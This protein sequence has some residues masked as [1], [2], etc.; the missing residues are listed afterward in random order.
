MA[1]AEA[2]RRISLDA[3][4]SI[5]VYTP[6]PGSRGTTSPYWGLQYRFV[7]VTGPHTAGLA[8]NAANEL[9]VGVLVNKPQTV[10]DAASVAISGVSY[11]QSGA[12]ITAGQ[13]LK[14]DSNGRAVPATVGTDKVLAIALDA[15]TAANQLIPGLLRV[16]N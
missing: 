16:S 8:T 2:Q 3:D 13:A 12:A 10:G 1:Y 5:G 4:A 15:C 6:P 11:L 9:T 14:A 7:K